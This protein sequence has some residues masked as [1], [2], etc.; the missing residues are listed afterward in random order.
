MNPNIFGEVPLMGLVKEGE[1]LFFMIREITLFLKH[2][3]CHLLEIRLNEL[4]HGACVFDLGFVRSELLM[5]F[6]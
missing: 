2:K 5:T 6:V 1:L 4:I 3:I